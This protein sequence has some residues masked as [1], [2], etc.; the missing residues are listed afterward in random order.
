MC[1]MM[2]VTA[3]VEEGWGRFLYKYKI[4]YYCYELEGGRFVQNLV[5]LWALFG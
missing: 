2:L 4:M 1:S 3:F 5:I